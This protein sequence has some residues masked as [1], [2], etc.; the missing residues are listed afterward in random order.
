MLTLEE[1]RATKRPATLAE[2]DA[3]CYDYGNAEQAKA[4]IYIDA[5]VIEDTGLWLK[6]SGPYYL[7]LENTDYMG[8]L[9]VLEQKLYEYAKVA[10][11]LE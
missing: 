6:K 7:L 4:L 3:L 10:G 2:L 8:D 9:E 11:F 5:L 1:F